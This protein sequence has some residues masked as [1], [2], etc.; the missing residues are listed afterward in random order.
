MSSGHVFLW[1]Y[2][3]EWDCRVIWQLYFQFYFKEFPYCV[4]SFLTSSVGCYIHRTLP[5]FQRTYNIELQLFIYKFYANEPPSYRNCVLVSFVFAVINQFCCRK[6]YVDCCYCCLVTKLCPTPCDPM[7]QPTISQA[8]IL[9]WGAIPFSRDLPD[10][11]IKP[12]SP[13]LFIFLTL[14][15]QGSPPK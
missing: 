2:A 4:R 9:Q 13:A 6:C 5:L 8:R 14:S 11:G 7:D 12:A 1:I 15:H 3:Q 10:S